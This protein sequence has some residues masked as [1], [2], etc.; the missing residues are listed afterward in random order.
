MRWFASSLFALILSGIAG[1]T[2]SARADTLVG[3]DLDYVTGIDQRGVDSGTGGMLRLGREYDWL[4]LSLTPEV[5]L[6]YYNF[7]GFREAHQ[8]AA[9]VGGRIAFGKVVEPGVFA[10]VGVGRLSREPSGDTGPTFDLGGSLDFTLLPILDLGVH[11]AYDVH[12][13]DGGD[14]VNWLRLGAQA[15][16]H[17]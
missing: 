9:V 3:L 10:H 2:R 12:L 16:I 11:G 8:I 13:A 4:A 14:S 7:S 15:T 5:G 1:Q 17:F 6:S